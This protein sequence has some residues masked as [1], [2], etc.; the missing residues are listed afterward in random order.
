MTGTYF[1]I[2]ASSQRF[3][4]NAFEDPVQNASSGF[5]ALALRPLYTGAITLT[6]SQDILKNS[7]GLKDQNIDKMLK[8]QSEINKLDLSYKL[9][10]PL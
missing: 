6:L 10:V 2:D 4:S 3:D 5:S 7:F 8:H 1:K 9:S